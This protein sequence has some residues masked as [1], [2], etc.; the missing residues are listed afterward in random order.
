MPK[1][2]FSDGVLDGR[3]GKTRAAALVGAAGAAPH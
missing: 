1:L 2:L 3:T